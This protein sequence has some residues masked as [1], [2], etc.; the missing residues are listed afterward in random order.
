MTNIVSSLS[1]VT[2]L[3]V[4][5]SFYLVGQD[6]RE[7]GALVEEGLCLLLTFTVDVVCKIGV[8]SVGD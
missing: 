3:S 7:N 2:H 6:N 1:T 5:L 4:S 8:I